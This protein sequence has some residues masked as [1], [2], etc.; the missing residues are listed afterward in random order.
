LE[1]GWEAYSLIPLAALGWFVGTSSLRLQ[2]VAV[3][4]VLSVAETLGL[5]IVGQPDALRRPTAEDAAARATPV[6]P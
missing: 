1:P 2:R 4:S 6:S 3:A 5:T